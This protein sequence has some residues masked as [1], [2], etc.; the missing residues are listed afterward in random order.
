MINMKYD[1]SGQIKTL[2]R[3]PQKSQEQHGLQLVDGV[4]RAARACLKANVPGLGRIGEQSIRIFIDFT[5]IRELIKRSYI[6]LV[7]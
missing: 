4:L 6:K 1:G 5:I 7:S 2:N 3:S